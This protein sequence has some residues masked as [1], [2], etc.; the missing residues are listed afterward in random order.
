MKIKLYLLFL[1]LTSLVF[2]QNQVETKIDKKIIKIGGQI[3]VTL[4]TTVDT[5]STVV[6]PATKSFG[7][8]EVIRNYVIDTVK[9]DDKYDLIKRYGLTQFD[10]GR[11]VIPKM[12]VLINK[13][14]FYSDT[15]NVNVKDVLVDT[16]KQKMYDIKPISLVENEGSNWWKYLLALLLLVGIAAL[17]YFLIKKY[18]TK[19]EQELVF[20]TPIEKAI[21][22]L[23][24][25]ETKQLWQ[26]GEIKTYYSELTD[27][28]RD[29]IEE[30]IE[31]PAKESTTSELI[32]AL[33]KAS[34]DK[35][36]KFTKQSLSNLENVLKQADLV[37]FAKVQPVQNQIE[38]DYKRIEKSI[39]SLHQSIPTDDEIIDENQLANAE[40][41][42]KKAQQKQ[43][44]TRIVLTIAAVLLLLFATTIYLIAT[45]GFSFVK[46]NILG[47]PTKEL[48]ETNWITSDYGNPAVTITTPKVLKRV[49]IANK[50]QDP[51]VVYNQLFMY[52]S[53]T[54]S[55]FISLVTTGFKQEIKP[56]LQ[57]VITAET[58]AFE[59][60]YKAKNIRLNQDDLTTAA[61]VVGRKA[62]GVMTI[63]NPISNQAT[64]AAF[65]IAVFNEQGGLQEIIIISKPDDLYAKQIIGRVLN[66]VELKPANQ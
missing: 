16:L 31:I 12:L 54:D 27:I 37:K 17:I 32:A 43:R 46:D 18:Q 55:F 44:T 52:G 33:K 13:K 34:T 20:K 65:D 35:K 28:A 57:D 64:I 3:N 66:S 62:S 23:K 21:G 6:F 41:I 15:I 5:L 29:Y 4:K 9:K 47:H 45:R 8:L 30:V 2:S 1:F 51:N 60:Q 59:T 10:S 19:K 42:K 24:I 63:I 40:L 7:Q 56:K 11:Y 22:M 36:L 39:I 49:V 25:L 50:P 48:L 61:G 38:E 26:N 58:K 14:P 53:V